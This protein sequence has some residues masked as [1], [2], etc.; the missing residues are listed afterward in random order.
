MPNIMERKKLKIMP[1]ERDNRRYFIA[2]ASNDKIEKAIR[3][4]IG[5]IGFA[6]SAYLRVNDKNEKT[7]GSCLRES[8]EEVRAS[9]AL[10]GI[11]IEKT[12]GTIKGLRYEN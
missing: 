8:L 10:A 9:L 11:N 3:N 1:S 6:R 7:I 5:I 4:Y 12:S 2:D